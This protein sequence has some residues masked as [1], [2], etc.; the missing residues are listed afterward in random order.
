M[1][2]S[3]NVLMFSGQFRPIV[4]GAERQAEKLA[5][6]LVSQGVRVTLLTPALVQGP[7]AEEQD[8]GVTIRRFSLFDI[9]RCLPGV[10]GFGPLNLLGL[11]CQLARVVDQHIQGASVLHA[12]MAGSLMAFAAQFARRRAVPVVCKVGMSGD[13]TDLTEL[14]RIGIGGPRLVRSMIQSVDRWIATTDAVRLS[15]TKSGVSERRI[16]SIPNGVELPIL[17]GRPLRQGVARRFLYLGRLSTTAD[18]D[19]PT[20]VRAFDRLADEALDVQLSIV[21]DGDLFG[22]TKALIARCRNATRIQLPGQQAPEPWVEWADCMVLPSR[23]EGL[24]NALLEAMS[25]GLVCIANDIPA[26]REVLAG[27]DAG[28]LTSVEGE[29]DLLHALRRVYTDAQLAG[30]LRQSASERARSAYDIRSVATRY[31]RLYEELRR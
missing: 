23:R 20:L 25:A 6:A 29:D 7:P 12:H 11:R 19:V 2:S 13:R 24:S 14:A 22:S 4:G 8:E 28:L 5:K 9:S 1:N 31:V 30:R 27:G 15:L 26:N 18:R 17:A 3:L 21:G 16:A 10:R